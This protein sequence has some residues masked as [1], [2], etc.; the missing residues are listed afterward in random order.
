MVTPFG[1]KVLD[2]KQECWTAAVLLWS[3]RFLESIRLG[4]SRHIT[5]LQTEVYLYVL[6]F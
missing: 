3:S 1:R 5:F 4:C 2:T 6:S